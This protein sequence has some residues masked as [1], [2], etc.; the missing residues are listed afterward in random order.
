MESMK[1]DT[2]RSA[3]QKTALCS[4]HQDESPDSPLRARGESRFSHF[5]KR[6]TIAFDDQGEVFSTQYSPDCTMMASGFSDGSIDIMSSMLGDKLFHIKDEDMYTPIMDIT[7]REKSKLSLA[8]QRFLAVN[9]TG[10]ILRWSSE[11]THEVKHLKL[12]EANQYQTID[13]SKCGHKFAVAGSLPHVELYDE[14]RPEK[15]IQQLGDCRGPHSNRVFIVRYFP[16]SVNKLY[17]AGWDRT[18]NLWDVRSNKVFGAITGT[19]ICGHSVDISQDGNT[20][21][22]GGGSAG[23]GLKVYDVRNL[24][25]PTVKIGWTLLS[26]DHVHNPLFNSVKIV[27]KNNLMIAGG[28]DSTPAKCFSLLTGELYERFIDLERA[29]MSISIAKDAS[30]LVLGDAAGNCHF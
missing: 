29:C 12:N 15:M 21:V 2:H 30:Q 19:Q 24:A 13:Y 9:A 17:S 16:D 25:E 7:W 6:Y 22:V 10:T 5:S 14:V 28:C 20:I 27:P 23:E 8:P 1:I 18:V 4:K 11:K 26:N 3:E